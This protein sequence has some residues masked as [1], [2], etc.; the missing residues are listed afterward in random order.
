MIRIKLTYIPDDCQKYECLYESNT[1]TIIK[2]R[3]KKDYKG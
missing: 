2:F 3:F 1:E